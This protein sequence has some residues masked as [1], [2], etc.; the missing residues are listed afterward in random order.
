MKPLVA[1]AI[2]VGAVAFVVIYRPIAEQNAADK[3]LS[4]V[5]QLEQAADKHQYEMTILEAV[6]PWIVIGLNVVLITAAA[7]LVGLGVHTVRFA[8]AK[9]AHAQL[10]ARA[11]YANERGQSP[12]IVDNARHP[13]FT[14][15]TGTGAIYRLSDGQCVQPPNSRMVSVAGY[16]NAIVAT[17]GGDGRRQPMMLEVGDDG[18]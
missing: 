13:R 6:R 7:V 4:N 2:I 9:V 8:G 10:A 15:D 3:H 5:Q 1:F 17:N 12:L 14:L 18:E 16:V 11:L